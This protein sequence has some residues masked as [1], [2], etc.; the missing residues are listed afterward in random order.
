MKPVAYC[1]RSLT[2]TERRYAQ[3]GKECLAGVWICK[4]FQ[5]H[6][7]GLEHFTL[8]TDHKPLVPLINSKVWTETPLCCQR[9][10]LKLV[11]LHVT[12]TYTLAKNMLVAD[13]PPRIMLG[14]D[15]DRQLKDDV[16]FNINHT[17]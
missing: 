16:I 15:A 1:W 3:F 5:R 4:S 13:T 14:V 9:M 11:R 17:T 10:L 7:A 6:L 8:Q 12:A 2:P